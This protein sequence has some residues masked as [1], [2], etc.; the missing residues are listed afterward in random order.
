MLGADSSRPQTARSDP[1]SHCFWISF[2]T[3]RGLWYGE[4]CRYILLQT[5]NATWSD[6]PQESSSLDGQ[7]VGLGR[8]RCVAHERTMDSHCL[9]A[10]C[11][12]MLQARCFE[13]R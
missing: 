7:L 8:D 6:K 13:E 2:C 1:T 12:P 5:G 10:D 4:H 9:L 3:S 11:C